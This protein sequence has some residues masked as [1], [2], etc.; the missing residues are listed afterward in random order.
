[1]FTFSIHGAK[2]YPLRKPESDLDI[3]LDDGTS[4]DEYLEAL[5]YGLAAALN[6]SG[7]DIAFYLAGADPYADDRLGRLALSMAGLAARDRLVFQACLDQRL[8]VAVSMA[9]GYARQIADTVAIQAETVKLA[10]LYAG[11]WPQGNGAGPWNSLDSDSLPSK[12][13]SL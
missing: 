7:A 6:R 2:N 13:G 3:P 1:M 9:G 12:G 8:P 10:S 5:K 11:R 4:D